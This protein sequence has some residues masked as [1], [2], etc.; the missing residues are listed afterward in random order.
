MDP[1]VKV[2]KMNLIDRFVAG[3]IKRNF[4]HSTPDKRD[5]ILG[6]VADSMR[7]TFHEDNCVTRYHSLIQ[8]LLKNDK[9]YQRVIQ[10]H[11]DF[12]VAM[13]NVLRSS[14]LEKD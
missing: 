5:M 1:L 4:S 13:G 11:P 10:S 3:Y 12:P 14:V 9:D 8:W 7:D 6:A 2:T